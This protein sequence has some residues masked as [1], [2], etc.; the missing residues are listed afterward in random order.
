[1]SHR[2]RNQV[3]RLPPKTVARRAL[4]EQIKTN[5][6]KAGDDGGLFAVGRQRSIAS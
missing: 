3:A 4:P 6:K 2:N 5:I 1:M